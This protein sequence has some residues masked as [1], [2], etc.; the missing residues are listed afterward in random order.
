MQDLEH[1][2]GFTLFDI[3]RTPVT[4]GGVA[5][6]LAVAV[7][8]FLAARL[9]G[10]GIGRVS[11]HAGQ[12]AAGLYIVRKLVTYGLVILGVVTG[13]ST[14]GLNLSSL[15]V[16]AGAVGVG[17]GLGLQGIVKE[18]VSGLVLIFD[19]V[20]GV[21]D[22]VELEDGKRGLVLEIGPRAVRVRTNDNVDIAIPN[23]KFIEGPV[24]NWTLHGSRRIHVPFGVAYGSDRRKVREVVLA[25]ARS[26]PFSLP[27]SAEYKSSVWLVGFGEFS[28]NFELLVW[29]SVEA[30]K[31]PAAMQA[32]YTWAIADALEAA[33]I[34]IP[35]PQ[36]DLH[37]RGLFGLRGDAALAALKLQP[38]PPAAG[39]ASRPAQGDNDAAEDLARPLPA[40]PPPSGS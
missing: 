14:M 7:V 22:F 32:A 5:A 12:A 17:V 31:R 6:G 29:P 20:M 3:G 25:A 26:V 1:V 9:A 28:L 4:L 35:N 23:S 24:V 27:D 30:V 11:T 16:F 8:F 15:A 13:L 2:G 33:G 40:P 37:I 18:F 19:R 39:S 38:P 10:Y 34:E 21:G 36:R